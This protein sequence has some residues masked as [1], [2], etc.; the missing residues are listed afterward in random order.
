MEIGRTSQRVTES[1]T[2]VELRPIIGWRGGKWLVSFNPIV[3]AALSGDNGHAPALAPALK[4]ARSVGEGVQIGI[5]N[6]ADMGPIHRSPAFNQQD[7]MIYGV[8]DVQKGG[9]DL[10]FGIGR[11]V[12]SASDKWVAKMIVGIPFK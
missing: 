4:I 1:N 11:G 3:G 2:N 5:E 7:H 8:V 12:T 6:Y 9:F 10:N